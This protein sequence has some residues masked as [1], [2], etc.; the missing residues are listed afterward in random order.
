LRN[1]WNEWSD[2]S[3]EIGRLYGCQWRSWTNS[4]QE[5]IDQIKYVI[6]GIKLN[7]FSRRHLV[8]AW[9][10]GELDQMSLPPCHVLFQF[11]VRN[12]FLSCQLYQRSGDVFLGLPFNIA[13]YSLLT[14]MIAQVCGLKAKKFIH[15]IGDA[16][17]YYNHIK[18]A[19]LQL[20]RSPRNLPIMK[21]N[22][23][24]KDIDDF[25]YEDFDLIDYDPHKHIKAK[26]A[27]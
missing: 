13:S 19:K 12:N 10:P 17:I 4:R 6:D 8:S 22:P 21:I 14:M 18:Q 25:V 15:V 1:I 16:H 11:Y 7:P 20:S 2:S 3:G 9:N 23:D 24:V 27:V 26:V 5:K